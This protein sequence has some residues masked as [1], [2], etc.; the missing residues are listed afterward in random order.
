MPL[1]NHSRPSSWSPKK[2]P[3]HKKHFLYRITDYLFINTFNRR[4][5]RGM[6]Q[7]V[8]REYG[9]RGLIQKMVKKWQS[10][11]KEFYHIVCGSNCCCWEKLHLCPWISFLWVY[12]RKAAGVPRYG[13]QIPT[14]K[15]WAFQCHSILSQR[16]F[17]RPDDENTVHFII[18]RR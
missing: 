13:S 16:S 15:G 4:M 3:D 1:K 17:F 11:R 5:R 18:Q 2:F 10:E 12:V 8:Y 9:M 7:N 6:L 14:D